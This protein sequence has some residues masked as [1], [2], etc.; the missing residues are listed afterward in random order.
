[1]IRNVVDS[2]IID[3]KFHDTELAKM[4]PGQREKAVAF[5]RG[6]FSDAPSTIAEISA[7]IARSPNDWWVGYHFTWGMA[8]RNLLRRNGFSE[9]DCG[10]QNL[11][12]IYVGLIQEA[13][14]CEQHQTI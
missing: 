13:F 3:K 2:T 9:A 5:L 6:Y 12:D 14:Q 8:V 10:V 1:M 7:A 11:D 4:Y